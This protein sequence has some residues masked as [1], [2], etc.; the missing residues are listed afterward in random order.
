MILLRRST[1]LL[2]WCSAFLVHQLIY[3][4]GLG[5]ATDS[6][7][8]NHLDLSLPQ[9]SQTELTSQREGR[10]KMTIPHTIIKE[11]FAFDDNDKRS[12]GWRLFGELQSQ[13]SLVM[14]YILT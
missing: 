3:L 9:F 4:E 5:Y 14:L 10:L 8:T 1:H 13:P 11:V 6:S 12:R 2:P 7:L